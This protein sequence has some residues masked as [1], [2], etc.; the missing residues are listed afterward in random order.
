MA[1][2][3]TLL[4]LLCLF[5]FA[6]AAE[7]REGNFKIRFEP[8]ARLQSK[9]EVPFEI[10]VMDS[11][12]QPLQREARVDISIVQQDREPEKGIRAFFIQPRVFLAKPVFP[13]DGQWDVTVVARRDNQ[14]T[15]RT[16]TFS[17]A[18]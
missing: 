4:A 1:I 18:P 14:V 3:K 6:N 12:G 15:R 8:T 9:T 17:V 5:F 13:R 11:R 2:V 10:H 16:T 7:D